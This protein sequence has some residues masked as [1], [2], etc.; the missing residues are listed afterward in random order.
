MIVIAD[1]TPLNYLILIR[2][3]DLLP[4]LFDRVLIPPAVFD[5]L[6]HLDTP[7]FVRDWITR[8]PSWLTIQ[9]LRS[10][11]DPSLS[12][13]DA[14][15]REAIAMAEQVHADQ[16]LLD[17]TEARQEAARRNLPFI[18]TLGVLREGARRDLLDLPA[19]LVELQ[20]TTFYVDPELIR[21]LMDEDARRKQRKP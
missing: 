8:R 2:Q 12:H 10:A 5:E 1:A 6:Q 20:E 3:A 18:G 15:E 16:L 11:P 4:Q 14:G 21:S 17:E 7:A 19:T 13:L 9:P